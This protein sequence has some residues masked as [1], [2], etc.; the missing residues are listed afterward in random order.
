MF[1]CL[2][3]ATKCEWSKLKGFV[4]QFNRVHRT[5]Y[6][7]SQCLDIS[8]TRRPQPEFLVEDRN[9]NRMVVEHKI[10]VWPPDSLKKH[11]SHHDFMDYFLQLISHAF[12]DDLYVLEVEEQDIELKRSSLREL[13]KNIGEI[14]L[15]HQGMIKDSRGIKASWPVSWSF[16]RLPDF[17]R[18]NMHTLGVGVKVNRS[19]PPTDELYR[20]LTEAQAEIMK[21]VSKHLSSTCK[22]FEDYGDCLRI[23]ITELYGSALLLDHE[24]LLEVISSME[25][26]QCID[27]IWVGYPEWESEDDCVTAYVQANIAKRGEVS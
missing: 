13:A 18:G 2:P 17:E 7:L 23:F 12:Q 27:Q 9:G 21:I 14:V 5:A 8:Y 22:K 1:P 4:E 3:S 20:E 11:R 10:V 19:M 15:A 16:R 24:V 6:A 25:I 26:P